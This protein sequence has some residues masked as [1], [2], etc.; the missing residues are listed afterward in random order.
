MR[1]Q[2]EVAAVRGDILRRLVEARA[3]TDA[4]FA[5]IPD[6]ALAERPI[7]E[8]HRLIFYLGNLEAFDR[9]L[10]V[11]DTFGRPPSHP[12]LDRLFAFGIDPVDGDLPE[13]APSD[14]PSPDAV[15]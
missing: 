8:R 9:N 7:P 6:A 3:E 12:G 4:L 13:D 15:R 1:P 10:I 14:W 2:R 5:L 11:R